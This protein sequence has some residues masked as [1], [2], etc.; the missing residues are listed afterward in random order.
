MIIISKPQLLHSSLLIKV[1]LEVRRYIGGSQFLLQK[2]L[3]GR[4]LAWP[5]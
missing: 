5:N 3:E 2:F 4:L 1:Q